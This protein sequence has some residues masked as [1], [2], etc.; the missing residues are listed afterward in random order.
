MK[1]HRSSLFLFLFAG[2]LLSSAPVLAQEEEDIFA[3][4]KTY[5]VQNRKFKLGNQIS[6]HLGYMPMDS[7]TKGIVLGASYTKYFSDFTG[8]EILNVNWVTS[9]DTGLRKQLIN[10]Y[11]ANPGDLPDFPEWYI[12]SNLV[13]TPIYNKNLLFNKSIVWGD[14]TFVGGPGFGSFKNDDIKPL[15]NVGAVL[16]FFIDQKKSFKVDI[17]ENLPF[18]STGVEPFLFIGASYTYQFDSKVEQAGDEENFDKEF[19]K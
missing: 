16:R 19:A 8:W 3:V 14:I 10:D 13:Y 11:G 9:M 5:S 2:V 7:F 12:T 15:I 1:L 17:R 18:L 6:G 4:P